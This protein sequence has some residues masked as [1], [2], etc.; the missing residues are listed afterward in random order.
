MTSP[1]PLRF[2]RLRTL[3]RYLLI[4]IVAVALGLFFARKEIG[5]ALAEK[6][7]E[8]LLQAGIFV[9]WQSAYWVPGPGIKLHELA[10]YRDSKKQDRLA[11]LSNVT[12][13]KSDPE[14]SIWDRFEVEI[15]KADLTLDHGANETILRD[16]N[17]Q[18]GIDSEKIVL[19]ESDALLNGLKII[20]KGFYLFDSSKTPSSKTSSKSQHLTKPNRSLFANINLNWLPTFKKWLSF[21]SKN[22]IPVLSIVVNSLPKSDDLKLILAL[23]GKNFKWRGENWD[24]LHADVKTIIGDNI[25]PIQINNVQIGHNGKIAKFNG[26]Y[27]PTH[28]TLKISNLDSKIDLLTLVKSL[29]PS[30]AESL[31]SIKTS[32]DW[33][34]RGEGEIPFD[35]PENRH[36]KGNCALNGEL[37]YSSPNSQITVQNPQFAMQM[38]N[39]VLS[40]R[41]LEANIWDGNLNMPTMQ[42]NF[43]VEQSNTKFST[44]FA[45]KKVKLQSVINSFDTADKQPGIINF[46]WKGSGEFNLQSIAGSGK[47]ELN[48]AEFFRI[49]LIGS[50]YSVF[51]KLTPSFDRTVSSAMTLDHQIGEGILNINNLKFNSSILKIE[52]QGNIDLEKQYAHL[53]AEAKLRGIVGLATALISSLLEVEGEGPVSNVSWKLKYVPGSGIVGNAV[54]KTGGTVIKGAD[55]V[56]EGA[57]DVV[58]GIFKFPSRLLKRDFGDSKNKNVD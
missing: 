7:E 43:P 15:S 12:A 1:L 14:W 51:E 16:L 36:W 20:A 6:L 11:L 4:F 24:I 48:G 41:N 9:T 53:T 28:S 32:G 23:D 37:I 26:I 55:T 56:V 21:Q 17:F 13:T 25:S 49:P 33:N 29:V 34:V 54:G 50:L 31:S 22:E 27:N 19:H 46:D 2:N 38:E 47:L 52:A 57:D 35:H 3:F 39:E 10:L 58:K 5:N 8:R 30:T 40:I 44:E 45:L 42:I 18:L